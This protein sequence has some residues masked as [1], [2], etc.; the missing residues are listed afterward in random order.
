MINRLTDSIIRQGLEQ[1]TPQ[2][3]QPPTQQPE[4]Q[5]EQPV[6]DLGTGYATSLISE[7]T[8]QEAYVRSALD[9]QLAAATPQPVQTP[10]I[11]TGSPD[12]GT[13]GSAASI[14]RELAYGS[15]GEDVKTLQTELNKWRAEVGYDPLPVTG[16]FGDQ[17]N[18]RCVLC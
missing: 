15:Q 7:R 18:N 12:V 3:N 13:A 8:T 4:Q 6:R 14:Q 11:A 17:R 2:E 1:L 16:F 9:A 10:P 5:T